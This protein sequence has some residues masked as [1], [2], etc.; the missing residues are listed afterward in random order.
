M[1]LFYG[2]DRCS[3]RELSSIIYLLEIEDD[4]F[5]YNARML[6]FQFI[7]LRSLAL[8][9]LLFEANPFRKQKKANEQRMIAYKNLQPSKEL[10]SGLSSQ[11]ELKIKN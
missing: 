4:T 9:A 6:I 1:I 5:Y 11:L 2:F 10:I 8:M 7:L 3:D